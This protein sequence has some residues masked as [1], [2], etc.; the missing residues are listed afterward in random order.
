MDDCDKCSC[1]NC[2]G[3]NQYLDCKDLDKANG[4]DKCNAVLVCAR[5]NNCTGQPCYCGSDSLLVCAFAPSGPCKTEIEAAAG[6]AM[7]P[8]TVMQQQNQAGSAL[9]RAYLADQCRVMNC[10][11]TCRP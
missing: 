10:K 3:P 4:N 2:V 6:G 11:N 7:D 9:N 8:A 5:A 1:M